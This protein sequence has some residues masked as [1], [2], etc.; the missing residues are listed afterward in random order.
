ML[1]PDKEEIFIFRPEGESSVGLSDRLSRED[2]AFLLA[3]ENEEL[4]KKKGNPRR[5]K[6]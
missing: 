6:S 4:K 1:D 5:K 2:E 3:I